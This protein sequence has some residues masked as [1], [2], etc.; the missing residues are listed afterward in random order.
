M[1]KRISCEKCEKKFNK[2][3]TFKVHMAKFHKQN[4]AVMGPALKSNENI[5]CTTE[6]PPIFNLMTRMTLRSNSSRDVPTNEDSNA[7]VIHIDKE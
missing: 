5:V 2:N 4:P 7:P 6:C 3:E 1:S